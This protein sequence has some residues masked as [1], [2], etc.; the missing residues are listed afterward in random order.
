MS[1]NNHPSFQYLVL[2]RGGSEE[3]RVRR[4]VGVC[5]CMGG[6]SK[7][8]KIIKWQANLVEFSNK[9]TNLRT[10]QFATERHKII[11]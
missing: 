5:V 4:N 1:E 11:G 6:E 7:Q 2:M 3:G 10:K 8:I 9:L